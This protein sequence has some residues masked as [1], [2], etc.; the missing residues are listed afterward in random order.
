MSGT[1]SF[2][3][4]AKVY[5][6]GL[7]GTAT[8]L[9]I[10]WVSTFDQLPKGQQICVL[11]NSL[12]PNTPAGL[13]VQLP[14]PNGAGGSVLEWVL[15]L[16]L[17][18]ASAISS[19]ALA[20]SIILNS[21]SSLTYGSTYTV[22]QNAAL[23]SSLTVRPSS[24][25]TIWVVASTGALGTGITTLAAASDFASAPIATGNASVASALATKVSTVGT[26]ATS[27]ALQAAFPAGAAGRTALVGASAPY[28]TYTDNGSAWS[29]AGST[30]ITTLAAASDFATAALATGNSS[31]ATALAAKVPNVGTFATSAALQTAFPAGTAG[32]V[33]QVGAS[34]PYV[35]YL[36]NGS[37]WVIGNVSTL[38][39]APDFS[40]AAL[41]TGNTSISSALATTNANVT[42]LT[43]TVAGKVTNVG[44]FTSSAALQA[45]FPAGTAGRVAQIGSVAPYVEYLDNGSAWGVANVSSLA[46]AP[47]F[48]TAALATGNTSISTALAT[49]AINVGTFATSAALQTAFPAGTAG[50]TAQVGASAPYTTYTDNGSAWATSG[51][52][53]TLA[54][55]SD[56]TTAAL[57]SGNTSISTALG[58]KVSNLGVFATVAALPASPTNGSTALVGS[59][60]PY[61]IYAYNG[62]SWA[63]SSNATLVAPATLNSTNAGYYNGQNVTLAAGATMT[64]DI[65]A[66]PLIAQGVTVFNGQSGTS[67]IAFS[68]GALKEN[69]AGTSA[70]NVTLGA[71]GVYVIT[72]SPTGSPNFRLVGGASL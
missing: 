10:P 64:I 70:A 72:Q 54:A 34:A 15:G 9:N 38:A 35:E 62:S 8:T 57:A 67:T 16:N 60:S 1:P 49:K 56:F 27:A 21:N 25:T 29:A 46:S 5:Y 17:S 20:T 14:V 18:D 36:D 40:T 26:F 50:R 22:W 6:N 65:T 2:F 24:S 4:P 42:A 45:A 47:D 58:G 37:A 71:C 39:S 55:A 28:T 66:Y 63:P 7:Q 59:A 68:G 23:V 61:T 13:Y 69:A 44:T 51:G 31:I 19:N 3:L 52:I 33:A 30:G 53:T 43:T 12:N 32:R 41:A 11:T 48:A